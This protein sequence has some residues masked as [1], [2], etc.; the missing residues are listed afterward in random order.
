MSYKV[1]KMKNFPKIKDGETPKRKYKRFLLG[2]SEIYFLSNIVITR[3]DLLFNA[4]NH[5][6]YAYF[7]VIFKYFKRCVNTA[8]VHNK[9]TDIAR[10]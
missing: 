4:W 10:L 9:N 3:R 2:S 6:G 5:M 7:G 8:C 1:I